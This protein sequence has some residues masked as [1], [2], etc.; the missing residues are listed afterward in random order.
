ML[1]L[2]DLTR[3]RRR[4]IELMQQSLDTLG[5]VLMAVSQETATTLRDFRDGP[6]GWTVLEVLCHLRD[7]DT[8]FRKRAEMM[9]DQ[10]TLQ[11]PSYDHEALAHTGNYN[12]QELRQVYAE[13]THSRAATITFFTKLTAAQWACRGIHPERG[14]FTMTDAAIQVGTHDMTHLE[15]ITRILYNNC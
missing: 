10:E 5:H 3:T 2:L 8:I 1:E 9:R 13:L 4:H 12:S 6:K 11:L 14:P 15:Q 7:Y